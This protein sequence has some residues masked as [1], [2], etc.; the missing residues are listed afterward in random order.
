MPLSA[1]LERASTIRESRTVQAADKR[2]KEP[3]MLPFVDDGHER[4]TKAI[5]AEVEATYA[6]QLQAASAAEKNLSKKEIEAEI[7]E[8]IK[9]IAPPDA[10]Y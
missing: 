10:L 1:S 3:A 6:Q 5:R 9:V 7:R 2:K 8:R 4:A